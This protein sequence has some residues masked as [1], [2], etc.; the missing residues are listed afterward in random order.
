[1]TSKR[2][3][4]ATKHV[5]YSFERTVSYG[6]LKSDLIHTIDD[7][8]L[9]SSRELGTSLPLLSWEVINVRSF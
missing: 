4:F 8:F 6:I 2:I 1:M 9:K 5:R 7:D 3:L